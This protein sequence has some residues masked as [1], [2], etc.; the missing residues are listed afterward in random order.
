[1]DEDN[2]F[3]LI[4]NESLQEHILDLAEVRAVLVRWDYG[5]GC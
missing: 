3:Q 1:M 2:S 4:F 5:V